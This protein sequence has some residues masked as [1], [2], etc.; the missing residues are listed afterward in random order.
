MKNS[1]TLISLVCA[2]GAVAAEAASDDAWKTFQADVGKACLAASKDL[3]ENGKAVVD[4]FGSPSYGLAVVTGKARGAKVT[5]S[6]ICAY[7]KK[8][9]KAEVG[10]EISADRLNVKAGD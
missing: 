10:G 3:I 7:D 1:V 4:P 6:T 9:R 8:T 5:I 2:F